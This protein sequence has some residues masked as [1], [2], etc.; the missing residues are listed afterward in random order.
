MN[1]EWRAVVG[2]E[3]I[4]EVSSMGR[5]RSIDRRV[6]THRG[7][8]ITRGVVLK[9]QP[10][11]GAYLQVSL[12]D[13]STNRTG[14]HPIH[15]LVA[16]AFLGPRPSGLQVA[17]G[18]GIAHDNRSSNLR[19][20]TAKENYDDRLVHSGPPVGATPWALTDDEVREVRFLVGLG[21][22]QHRVAERFGISQPYVSNIVRGKARRNVA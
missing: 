8:R 6:A 18:N 14:A 13:A 1:E 19:Y 12:K 20:A 10:G 17:H 16:R 11:V 22:N 4:Y 9:P 21:H 7:S 5:V 15:R 3:G 2:Y